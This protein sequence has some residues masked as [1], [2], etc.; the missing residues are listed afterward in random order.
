MLR[1]VSSLGLALLLGAPAHAQDAVAKVDTLFSWV[2]PGMPGCAVAVAQNGEVLVNRA[3][4]LANLETGAPIGPRTVFDIGSVQKQFS[5]A[6]ALLLV[7]EGRLS[8]SADIREYLPELPDNGHRVTLDHLMTHT[9]GVRDWLALM[10]FNSGDEDALTLILRQHGL[11]FAPGERWAYSNSNFELVKEIVARVSGMSFSEFARTRLF[12]PLGMENAMYAAD[13]TAAEHG[14]R[15]YEREGD[16]WQPAMLLGVE[17]GGGAV[18][19]TVSDLLLWNEA[20]TSGRLGA[21]VTGRL[22][23]P[24]RLNNGRDLTY[25]RGLFAEDT[26]FGRAVWHTGSARAFGA[27]LS[28]LPDHGLSIAMLCN[29]GDAVD[30][31]MEGRRIADLFLPEGVVREVEAAESPAAARAVAVDL[32]GKAGLFFSE[33]DGEP[34][35][36]IVQ[37]GRL[38]VAGG[39]VLVTVAEDRFRNPS[40]RLS[41]MS[42]DEFEL[43]FL[44]PDELVL[45]SM[46]GEKARYRR[47]RPYAPGAAELQEFAGRYESDDLG[48][49]FE[50]SPGDNAVVIR[51]NGAQTI[52]FAPVD[53]DTFQR[54]PLTVRFLRDDTGQVTALD[55]STPVLRNV[56][57]ARPDSE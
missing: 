21:F 4:G 31:N 47:A 45:T 28:R 32:T 57:F 56:R 29:A 7:E 52:P 49:V 44:S 22:Q 40:G 35:R 48:A 38:R 53:P 39:P 46:E 9:S 14:A 3:Y 41:F 18:L 19:S 10:N 42:E 5:A 27:L 51:L 12:E 16:V 13:I 55:F 37:N 2:T 11:N 24:A 26:P 23:E 43:H 15:A 36:L 6:A 34:L 50:T 17:R 1:P 25:A 8:L 33:R 20:L 30:R 54:G